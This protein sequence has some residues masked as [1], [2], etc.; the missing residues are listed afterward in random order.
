MKN[1]LDKISII[2]YLCF[3]LVIILSF[4]GAIFAVLFMA[5]KNTDSW[6]AFLGL[7]GLF[8]STA[9]LSLGIKTLIET[10]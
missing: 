6:A 8:S 7:L 3:L 5:Y 1:I 10:K 9:V 2:A 4:Y